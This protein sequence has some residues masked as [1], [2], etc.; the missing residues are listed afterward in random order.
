MACQRTLAAGGGG[1]GGGGAGG[2]LST[3]GEG[4]ALPEKLLFW[5]WLGAMAANMIATI[6]NPSFIM[7]ELSSADPDRNS[8][9]HL[10]RHDR[11][12]MFAI[13]ARCSQAGRCWLSTALRR[14]TDR[15]PRLTVFAAPVT[16]GAE[17][18]SAAS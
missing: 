8:I 2:P 16:S 7:L 18:S 15:L 17:S 4:E 5:A 14:C 10:A 1:A 6:S 13:V 3:F 11:K 12:C 9:S